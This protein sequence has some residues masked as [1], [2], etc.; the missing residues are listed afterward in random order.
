MDSIF[1]EYLM[2]NDV[3]LVCNETKR[4]MSADSLYEI[5]GEFVVYEGRYEVYRGSDFEEANNKL[6]E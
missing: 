5:Q 2:S 4:V 3:N 6:T 1:L